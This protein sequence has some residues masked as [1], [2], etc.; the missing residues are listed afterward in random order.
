MTARMR[1]AVVALALAGALGG[2]VKVSTAPPADLPAYVRIMP[3]GQQKMVMDMGLMKAEIF[4]T[5]SSV[6]DVVAFYRAQA[7][8]DGLAEQAAQPAAAGSD[9]KQVR[10]ADASNGRLVIVDAMPSVQE[11]GMTTVTLTYM[12]AKPS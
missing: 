7:Q 9:N 2:C 3:G 8:S 11:P 6:D 5:S 12:P 10:F 1:L 4:A